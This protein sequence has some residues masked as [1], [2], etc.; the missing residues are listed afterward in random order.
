MTFFA[1]SASAALGLLFSYFG[2]GLATVSGPETVHLVGALLLLA[3]AGVI[4]F[5]IRQAK[6]GKGPGASVVLILPM[7]LVIGVLWVFQIGQYAFSLLILDSGIFDSE[8][9]STGAQ[10]YKL[11]TS[12]V[13][14]IAKDWDGKYYPPFNEFEVKFGTR[15]TSLARSDF[16]YPKSIKFV[17]RK[18]SRLEGR[19]IQGPDG[20][21]I[22]FPE[23][24][25]YYAIPSLTADVV[26]HYRL[27]PEEEL[28][29]AEPD[30]GI[31]RYEVTVTDR[32]T[33]ERLASLRYIID[34]KNRRGC[35]LTGRNTM[36]ERSFVLKAIG[37][38]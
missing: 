32:R 19:P 37:L 25:A 6:A 33:G 23:T 4:V 12:P 36:S 9:K 24:G 27:E 2:L 13:G 20:P 21:Y 10:Y 16:P 22:R 26:V 14:S 31:V 38:E 35:G 15:I 30:Q 8:C 1:Y 3:Y 18:S 7:F 34:A 5:V 28:K 17:E 29:K 11:P